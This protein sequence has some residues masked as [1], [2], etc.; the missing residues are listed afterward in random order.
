MNCTVSK[1]D[2]S[3]PGFRRCQ[4]PVRIF[5][6]MTINKAQVQSISG[7]LGINLHSQCFSHGK[8]HVALSRK[9]NPRN[10]F[11]LTTDGSKRTRNVAFLELFIMRHNIFRVRKSVVR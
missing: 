9:T 5:F 8:L 10:V 2:F 4:F 1:D 3:I 6:A 11:I 7:T